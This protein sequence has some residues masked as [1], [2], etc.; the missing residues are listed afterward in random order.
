M[1]KRVDYFDP[2]EMECWLTGPSKA[3]VD[4]HYPPAPK[5]RSRHDLTKAEAYCLK[6]H[7]KG[8]PALR[9]ANAMN[10]AEVTVRKYITKAQAK[11][12]S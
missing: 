6:M 8:W 1:G 10:I 5:K 11:Q 7:N 2:H 3:P 4:A 12:R 9:I